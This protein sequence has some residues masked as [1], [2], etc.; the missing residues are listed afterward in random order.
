MLIAQKVAQNQSSVTNNER[1]CDRRMIRT[2][3]PLIVHAILVRAIKKFLSFLSGRF[4][5]LKEERKHE[6]DED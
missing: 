4:Q 2:R 6:V 1:K 3:N 5:F